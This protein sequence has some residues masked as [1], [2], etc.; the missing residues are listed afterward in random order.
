MRAMLAVAV[1]ARYIMFC[2]LIS[3]SVDASSSQITTR[4]AARQMDGNTSRQAGTVPYGSC[5]MQ[6]VMSVW[7]QF[8]AQ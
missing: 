3:A 2:L 5:R 8:I 7:Y 6:L 1:Y 4:V